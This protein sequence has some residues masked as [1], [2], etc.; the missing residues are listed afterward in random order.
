[1]KK[2]IFILFSLTSFGSTAQNIVLKKSLNPFVEY[3]PTPNYAKGTLEF[4]P[5]SK[6]LAQAENLFKEKKINP[7]EAT[8]NDWNVILK[9]VGTVI[10]KDDTF[11]SCSISD[12][13]YIHL[14]FINNYLY[15]ICESY[16]D[17]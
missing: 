13:S 16:D 2:F 8:I 10:R 7:I 11:L 1:M 12:K 5:L 4:Q 14:T 9:E 6:L 15:S 17:E 3:H